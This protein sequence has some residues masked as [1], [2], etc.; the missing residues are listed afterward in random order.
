MSVLEVG[1]GKG[2]YTIEVAKRVPNGKVVAIDIQ[3]SVVNRLEQKC[4]EQGINNMEPK[5]MDC[6]N[7]PHALLLANANLK[8]YITE[9]G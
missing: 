3:E 4:R 9:Y 5:V 6:L 8:P 7:R 1:P 2:T